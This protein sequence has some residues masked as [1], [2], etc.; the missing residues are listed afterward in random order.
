MVTMLGA[1]GGFFEGM[2]FFVIV[3]CTLDA[4]FEVFTSG[5][6]IGYPVLIFGGVGIILGAAIGWA[7]DVW[8]NKDRVYV[9]VP[10]KPPVAGK[11]AHKGPFG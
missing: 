7:A 8:V 9:S 10:R 1:V 11:P 2:V 6:W 4:P 3:N 5:T